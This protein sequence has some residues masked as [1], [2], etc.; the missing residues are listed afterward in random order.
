GGVE[1]GRQGR[2][3]GVGRQVGGGE[4]RLKIRGRLHLASPVKDGTKR[5]RPDEA[6]EKARSRRT[7]LSLAVSADA[8]YANKPLDESRLCQGFAT[9]R[10]CFGGFKS[11][12]RMQG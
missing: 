10:P 1:Q 11:P 5:S 7:N 9:F 2:G 3:G 12:G 6:R 8:G 4:G